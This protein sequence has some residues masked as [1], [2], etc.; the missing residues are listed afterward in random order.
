MISCNSNKKSDSEQTQVVYIPETDTATYESSRVEKIIEENKQQTN[1]SLTYWDSDTLNLWGHQPLDKNLFLINFNSGQVHKAKTISHIS[2]E[3]PMADF[4]DLTIIQPSIFKDKKD[5][6][7]GMF[8][9]KE[10]IDFKI[11]KFED[12]NDKKISVEID[13]LIRKTSMI[14]SLL[15][16]N[17]EK[18]D[19]SVITSK[20]IISG[21]RTENV[22][23]KIVTYMIFD[24]S[25]TGPR[26]AILNGKIYPISGQCSFKE[27]I[28]YMIDNELFIKSGASCCDCGIVI[29]KIFKV[30]NDS[31]TLEFNDGSQSN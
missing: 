6:D 13:S 15:S 14:D 10:E 21:L 16:I 3:D 25:T 19:N 26:F 5:L 22:D 1:Y 28:P 24:N 2:K 23:I 17:G 8:S 30:T 11:L 9:E 7:L 20:P 4:M 12:I 29:D 18:L 31:I 27:I